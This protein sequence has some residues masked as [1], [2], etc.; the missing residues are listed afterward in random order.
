MQAAPM[1]PPHPPEPGHA[2]RFDSMLTGL[3]TVS[4]KEVLKREADYRKQRAAKKK[5]AG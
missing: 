3:F 4:K 1:N 5:K 2:Q